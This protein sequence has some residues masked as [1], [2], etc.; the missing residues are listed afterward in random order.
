MFIQLLTQEHSIDRVELL[1]A[2]GGHH[3]PAQTRN[4][5]D[6][7]ETILAILNDCSNRDT[8]DLGF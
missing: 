6:C 4:C 7:N 1:Q 5:V 3:S 2:A 8:H